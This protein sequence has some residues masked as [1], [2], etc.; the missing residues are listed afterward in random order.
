MHNLEGGCQS[1]MIDHSM[2]APCFDTG[3][4]ITKKNCEV[5]Y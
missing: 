4:K 1:Q 2:N 5:D 3:S